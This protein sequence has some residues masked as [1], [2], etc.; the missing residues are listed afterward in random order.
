MLSLLTFIMTGCKDTD[1]FNENGEPVR[2]ELACTFSSSVGKQTR[3]ADNLV[4]NSDKR[5]PTPSSLHIIALE[6]EVLKISEVSWEAPVYKQGEEP[7]PAAYL[8]HSSYCDMAQGVNRCLVYGDVADAESG[9][10]PS[11]LYNGSLIKSP[12][13][14]ITTNSGLHNVSFCLK[15]IFDGPDIP[16]DATTLAAAL[17]DVANL[18]DWVSS[19]NNTLKNLR[20][21]FINHG[22]NLPG[23]A[24]S[25]K[26]WLE[27]LASAAQSYI[28]NPSG[29][30]DTE[31]AILTTINSAAGDKVTEIGDIS[32]TS[33]PRN[34][35]LPDGAAALR[36]VESATGGEF[37][38]EMQ[39][40]T[41]DNI[42]TVSR[43]AYP[44]ALYYFVDSEI[45]TSNSKV[46]YALEYNNVSTTAEKTAWDQILE[47][48]FKDGSKVTGTTKAVALQS[49]MQYAVA[50][51][52]V[53][54]K[55]SNDLKDD[56]ETDILI[57]NG[58]ETNY[59]PLTG[60]IVCG[61]RPVNYLFEQG[62]NS[63]AEVKFIYD[64]QV[65]DCYLTTTETEACN[66]LVLQSFNGE[67]V[68]IILEFENSGNQ[69]FKCVDGYVYPGTRFY[70]VGKVDHSNPSSGTDV[71]NNGR[72]FTK[73]YIT[74][75]N[76]TVTSLAKAYNV[77]PN[78][79]TS[80]LEIGVETT[81]DWIAV[82]PTVVRME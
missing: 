16:S 42:N 67:D 43:F 54:V 30:T 50:Q 41:L 17:T 75:V 5:H 20:Q 13:N 15:S 23:S 3:Q 82:T 33:Y 61:Q 27:A 28:N 37:K 36:W 63:D 39:T 73:D 12:L 29:L 22:F 59:F 24:A 71:T 60:I 44:A 4:Q 25:V 62:S 8:Y 26:K 68:N 72:V 65:N 76:M 51:L 81:P 2:V 10:I 31:T 11:E 66:T 58:S 9:S 53:T 77:L 64:S 69:T 7:M 45:K 48:E 6:D 34:L 40:T 38:P 21:N 52:H 57:N 56:N 1:G 49:P 55:A 79:L 80:N 47:Q 14:N 46:D 74:T 35:Y 70:L 78:L 19:N 18:T 32:A